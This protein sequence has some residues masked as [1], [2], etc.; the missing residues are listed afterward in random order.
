M[1]QQ[2]KVSPLAR[3]QFE[4]GTL[5]AFDNE[6]RVAPLHVIKRYASKLGRD[7]VET[8]GRALHFW[9]GE[10]DHIQMYEA[11]GFSMEPALYE[12]RDCP[13]HQ[14]EIRR[15]FTDRGDSQP[16]GIESW[17]NHEVQSQVRRATYTPPS[18]KPE[19]LPTRTK[20]K[21]TFE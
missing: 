18:P 3:K 12:A 13:G 16:L 19:V 10:S 6:D 8:V 20:R 7:E 21:I 1:R 2:V 4:A 17:L 5:L 9:D 14:A 11:E 15:M